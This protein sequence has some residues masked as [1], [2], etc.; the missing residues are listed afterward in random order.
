MRCG[1]T[2]RYARWTALVALSALP[3]TA[4]PPEASAG[5][6]PEPETV[7]VHVYSPSM[8]RVVP[9]AVQTPADTSVP[10][11]TLYLLNGAGGG[12]DEAT[13]QHQADVESFFADK[14]VN[15][16]TPLAGAFSYYTD[17]QRDDPE[18]G[19]NKWTTFLT[20][21]LPPIIDAEFGTSGVN[22]IAG[23]SMAGTSVL[24]LAIAAPSL[25]RGIGAYSGCAETSTDAGQFYVRTVV[26]SRGGADSENMWGPL[27]GPGWVANDPL[28]NAEKLRGTAMF[29]SSSTGLPGEHDTLT[30]RSVDG[31][32]SVLANQVIVGGI[33]EAAVDSCTHRLASRFDE[34]GIDATFD[35]RPSGTHSW[36][37]WED[38]LHES[39]PM[40]ATAMGW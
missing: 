25:Y 14:N 11:P 3:L 33:I 28:V 16:V 6:E 36:G 1:Q 34:L 22:A 26:E 2:R 35:F 38:D 19:R 4:G 39:W 17:W 30:A 31:D 29:I 20:Q 8:D 15:V 32:P 5:P 13:W 7:T 10:R 21:E 12:E 18:L 9:V 40:L 24:S 27:G 37:Y 23:I